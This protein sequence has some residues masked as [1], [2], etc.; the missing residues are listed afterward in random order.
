M[1]KAPHFG[2]DRTI[3]LFEDVP[4]V[5][6]KITEINMERLY[7]A[8]VRAAHLVRRMVDSFGPDRLMWGSDMGQSM[9]WN[10]TE[11]TQM[12]Y[13]ATDFLTEEERRKFL[14][15]NAARLYA[16]AG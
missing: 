10:Y 3:A 13:A 12:A 14:H 9:L 5:Y 8:G 2:I 7:V 15:D 11:K 1:P 16:R 4:N 6:F